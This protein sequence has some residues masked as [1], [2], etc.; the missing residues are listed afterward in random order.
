[1]NIA[2]FERC[3]NLLTQLLLKDAAAFWREM[4]SRPEGFGEL[5]PED[6]LE[7]LLTHEVNGRDRRRQATL[8]KTSR[9]P[10]FRAIE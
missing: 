5:S 3:Y 1:M 7:V 2:N 8:L 4:G 10:M 6:V 9:V